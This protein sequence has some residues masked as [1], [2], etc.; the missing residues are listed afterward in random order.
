MILRKLKPISTS[1]E[2]SALY[3][4]HSHN[5]S[6]SCSPVSSVPSTTPMNSIPIIL[7]DPRIHQRIPRP[8]SIPLNAPP[9]HPLFTL[10][11]PH[12]ATLQLMWRMVPSRG[13]YLSFRRRQVEFDR[14]EHAILRGFVVD[15]VMRALVRVSITEGRKGKKYL[16]SCHI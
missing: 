6:K 5:H 9:L 1:L 4:T 11:S 14:D 3:Q 8:L 15:L 2:N 7:L 12:F 13:E 16:N 10:H